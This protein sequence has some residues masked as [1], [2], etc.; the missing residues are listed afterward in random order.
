MLQAIIL[1]LIIV[2]VLLWLRRAPAQ[3][4]THVTAPPAPARDRFHCVEIRAGLPACEAARQIDHVRFL[5][6]EAP[7]IPV[8]DC[9]QPRCGCRY[10]H[11]SDRRFDERRNPYGQWSNLPTGLTRERRH[12]VERRQSN[13][14]SVTPSIR[15]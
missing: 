14:H 13:G 7:L 2:A 10:V 1:V 8:A 3:P 15:Y 11:H 4:S 5:A 9:D 6:R 12:R